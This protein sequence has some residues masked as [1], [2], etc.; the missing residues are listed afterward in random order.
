M[1]VDVRAVAVG[2][3]LL[4]LAGCGGLPTSGPV[5][6]G[7]PIAARSEPPYV[8]NFPV[9]PED[10]ADEVAIVEGF[11]ASMRSYVPGYPGATAYLTPEASTSWDPS[12]QIEVFDGTAAAARKVADG[13]VLLSMQLAGRVHA[14]G[15]YAPAADGETAEITIP[16]TQVDGEW[17]IA[18]P[19]PGLVL[20]ESQFERE[21]A[22]YEVYFPEPVSGVLVADQVMLPVGGANQSTLLVQSLLRGP[23]AWLSPAVATA[24]PEGTALVTDSVP[25]REDGVATVN[26]TEQA[27][28]ASPDAR[29]RLAAQLFVTLSSQLPAE[30][31]EVA[32]TVEGTPLTVPGADDGVVS[33]STVRGF[34]PT[35]PSRG[36]T[37]YAVLDG[38]VV[39]VLPDDD[40]TAPVG[41]AFG[42][43]GAGVRSVGVSL[44]TGS[45]AAVD[46]SGT[47]LLRARFEGGALD[48]MATG[49]DLSAPSWDREGSVWTVDR[50]ADG[51]RLLRASGETVTTVV[52]PELLP[53][54]VETVRINA[55]GVRVLLVAEQGERRVALVGLLREEQPDR[56]VPLSLVNLQEVPFEEGAVLDADWIDVSQI[57]VLAESAGESVRTPYIVAVSGLE[58]TARQDVTEARGAGGF[59]RGT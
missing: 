13:Q 11:L 8:G 49:T 26:L 41:G 21:Y 4:L 38:R 55:D 33:A 19:P 50:T 2:V 34:D 43:E 54:H 5:E 32:I 57:A 48:E 56:Q 46:A 36:S 37:I 17:R 30:I 52:A 29:S 40:A 14:D 59:A 18:G 44:D 53:W 45:A 31:R 47:R 25:V 23:T 12:A 10:G 3:M 7:V 24:F 27:R 51:S 6:E 58:P 28:T 35:S 22:P 15:T 39:T 20:S 9:E 42:E 16:L 1:R